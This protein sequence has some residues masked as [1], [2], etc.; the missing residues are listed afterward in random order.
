M[1]QTI[2][3]LRRVMQREGIDAW[4]SPSSDAHQSEYPTEYDKCRRFLS[5]FTGSAGTLLVMMEEA[6]LWTDG[7]YFLQAESE[8]KDSGITLMKMGEL[9]VPSLD[10]L[11]EEKMKKDEVL[12]FNG[13]LLSFSEGKVIANK[14][15]KKGV[16]LAIGKEITNEVWTDRPKRPHTKVFILEDKYAGKSAS[17]KISEVRERMNGKDLLIVSSLSDIAWLTNLR[18]F[19]IQ[20]NPL[21]LSYFILEMDKAILFIQEESLS[22]D[23]REYLSNN[24]IG[25]KPYDDFDKSVAA[26]KS[27][28]IMFDEA[29]VSY[30][31]FISISKK[32][33]ANKLYNV[34]SPVT[35][36][37]NIKN[38]IEVSNMKKSHIRDGVYMAKYMYWLKQ[39]I[40]NGAKLTEKTAS[41]YLDDL[42]RGD[43]L[44]LDLSFPTISGYA[45]NG[46][47]VHYEAEYDTAK[48]LEAK[49]LYL[50]DSGAT[51]M[52]GT[53][54]VTR[55]ISLGENT[56][57]ERLHYTLVT[58]GMLRLLNTTFKRGAIGA[59][60]DIKA[61]E[62]L[63]EYGLDYNHGTG[64]GVG[65]V[66]TV[67]EAPTSIRNKINKDLYRNLEFEP[68]M[69]MSD[70]PGVYISGKHGIRMEILM[71]V[72][73]KQD[74][75][76]GFE[77]L[78]MAP[79][80]NEPLLVEVMTKRDIE[81]Y[82]KYQKQVYEAISYGL[83]EE[84]KLWLKELTKE[85]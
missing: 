18:A 58:I 10:E 83:S 65:F 29:D 38:D 8:L 79:I 6:Y 73:E 64:H 80:D 72:V 43:E 63:W 44:F 75:F 49:G 74:G 69:I 71:T 85:I 48:E 24:G 14:V 20:C 1:K 33:N 56:Y 17:K 19:D 60:L 66:N 30:K 22:D 54:D 15:V 28:Q 34:L 51:Y 23:V 36:L 78:T 12:G 40:K 31:T 46:A 67:H 82:N 76:L 77:S 53:T 11:L 57:E 39:Q 52:D 70:E 35:Y 3:D 59:C 45:E 50:F 62:A 16:K 21:F 41:D 2:V 25:I 9:G 68:G 13:S 47:I 55:T 26:I 84:E 4:I 37:K 7:R 81:L 32:D 61:R 5:G 27:R 42:R